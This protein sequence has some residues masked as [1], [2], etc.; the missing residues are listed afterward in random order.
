ML[1]KIKTQL[2]SNEL[3]KL[4]LIAVTALLTCVVG[5]IVY[6]NFAYYETLL[7]SEM[8]EDLAFVREARS[9]GTLFPHEWLYTREIRLM[10]I[11]SVILPFYV[12][13]NDIHLSYPL[14][15]SFMLLLNIG[16]FFYML[17]Y[18]KMNLLPIVTGLLTL[19][20]FF[21]A[22]GTGEVYPIFNILWLNSSYAVHL[23]SILL[24]MGV[25]LRI[26]GGVFDW[27]RKNITIFIITALTALGQ[28]LQSD[29]LLIALY[30]PLF[31]TEALF[32]ISRKSNK[33]TKSS[34]FVAV[35]FSFAFFG[36]MLI[37]ALFST[38][39]LITHFPTSTGLSIIGNSELFSRLGYYTENLFHALGLI[40]GESLFSIEGLLYFGRMTSII[41]L[42]VIMRRISSSHKKTVGDVTDRS[43]VT[44]LT[45][46]FIFSS[47]VMTFVRVE[48]ELTS[49]Y[50]FTVIILMSVMVSFTTDHLM[51]NKQHFFTCVTCLVVFV[52]SVSSLYALPLEKNETL[53]NDRKAVVEFIRGTGL[54]YGYGVSWQGKVIE[55]VSYEAD[56]SSNDF[57]MF[58]IFSNIHTLQ[59]R[60]ATLSQIRH[61]EDE[62]FLILST[63]QA[64]T[65]ELTD[66][67]GPTLALGERHD[68]NGGWTVY[69]FSHNPWRVV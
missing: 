23:A 27:N 49:R 22:M 61:T 4:L 10:H 5:Y 31:I 19:I 26:R 56:S 32:L 51:K 64:N 2:K 9:Q 52:M 13:T 6:A 42:I 3:M 21:A 14:A 66:D 30:I 29:R 24:T 15:S 7:N 68:L 60:G 55:A 46:S 41:I 17:R 45:A 69:L 65:A 57:T 37:K 12:I 38:E 53:I 11:T 16:L 33:P 43:A 47:V 18:R 36:S 20:A 25:Y 40:G 59:H 8:A 35:L 48:V 67:E 39:T 63:V 50:L 34:F 44:L 62:V 28:G 58:Y 54:N 1:N